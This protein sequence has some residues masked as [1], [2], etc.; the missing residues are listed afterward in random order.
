MPATRALDAPL[1]RAALAALLVAA[2]LSS[3]S[4]S[5]LKLESETN[6]CVALNDHQ[7]PPTL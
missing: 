6:C 2:Y 3:A 5:F 7:F 4:S 1:A